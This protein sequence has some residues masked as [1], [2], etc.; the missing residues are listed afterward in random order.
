MNS[1]LSPK[2]FSLSP[3]SQP[4]SQH[5]AAV[6]RMNGVFSLW[7]L[8]AAASTMGDKQ[9]VYG[10]DDVLFGCIESQQGDTPFGDFLD[11]GTGTHSL[12]WIAT[13]GNE[14]GMSSFT[15]V[16]ADVT[17]K[18]NVEREAQKLGV[19]EGNHI[20]M[21][22]WFGELDLPKTQYD[23]ILADYLVGA[24]DGFSPYRQDEMIPKLAKLLKPG[25]RLYIVGLE[26]IPDAAEGP[27][28]VICKVRQVRDACIL[29]AGHRCYREYPVEWIEKQITR[30]PGLQLGKTDRFPI[31]YRYNTILR[32]INVGRSK[33]ASFPTP[34]LES[35]MKQVLDDLDNQAEQATINGPIKFGFDYVVAAVKIEVIE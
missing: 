29:L 8:L 15:A 6:V 7:S 28:N 3:I 12:R 19:L 23:T 26:P 33:F 18:L 14:K 21:G 34:A 5:V 27:R 4:S 24:M 2:I 35:A 1:L 16:T 20:V 32:Q 17:M 30:T 31:L 22:N 11:A 10:K 25:G 9:F 13:L